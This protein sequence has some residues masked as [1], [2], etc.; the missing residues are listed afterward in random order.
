M[1][2]AL[3]G[4][5]T[6]GG[7]ATVGGAAGRNAAQRRA[8]PADEA[9]RQALAF[10]LR[11]TVEGEVRFDPG[12]RHLY[13]T[14]ASNYR[15]LPLGV[16]TPRHADDVAATLAAC[17]DAEVPVTLRGAGTSLAGQATN[18][19]VVLDVSRHLDTIAWVDPDA[20]L[21]RVEPGVVLAS[22]QAAAAPH[23]LMFGPD[24]ST[25]DRCTLGG[26]IGN[27]ACG[28]HSLTTGRT[29]HQVESLD[30]LLADG[31]RVD[32]G[33]VT[34][35]EAMRLAAAD[36]PMAAR[37]H[38]LLSLRGEVGDL[39]RD[40]FPRVP[41]RVSGYH[42]DQL[43]HADRLDVAKALVGTE[44]TC[45]VVLGATVRLVER[46]AARVLV[47]LG[48]RDLIEAARHVPA[49]L[50]HQP[51]ALE[52]VD[53]MLV[54]GAARP[55]RTRPR[56]LDLLPDGDG[57]LV[58]EFTG[59][60]V[61]EA[62]DA[63]DRLVRARDE[64]GA[65]THR[66]VTD[67]ADQAAV[68]RVRAEGLGAISVAP[69]QAMK[70]SG[71]E[72]AGVAPTRLADYLADLADLV[73]EHGLEAG[74]YGHF[75][76][77]CV[78]TKI[79]FDHTTDAGVATFRRFV[80]AAA[81][82]VVAHGG[83]P[84][85]EHGDGQARAEL[86]RKVFG[87]EL[88]D[89][90]RRFKHAWDP[91]GLL[92]PG[93][94]V[95][96]LPLDEGLRL[97]PLVEMATPARWFALAE[98]DGDLAGEAARCVGM[99]V[100]V[101]DQDTGTMCPSYMV[102][103]DEQHSTRGRAHLLFEV[104][105]PDTDLDGID[106]AHLHEALD[107]CL[108]CKACKA[109][110]PTGVD[111]ATL[112]AEV[113][114]QRYADRR[115]PAE[116]HALGRVRWWLRA[117]SRLPRLANAL[118]GS[119]V[120]RRLRPLVGVTSERPVPRLADVRFSTWWRRRG[121]SRVEGPPV[122][123]FV[124]TF[125]ET[126]E[127]RIGAAAV[128]VLEAAGRRVV[129]ASRPVCCGR[130]LYDHGMLD[131]AVT[132][133]RRLVDVLG[134]VAAGG[135]P[136][137]GLEPSCVA[138]L[139]DELPSLLTDDPAASAV[140]GATRTLS[141]FLLEVDWQPEGALDD[142]VEV[143]LHPHCQGRAVVGTDAD[144]ALLDRLGA[145]WRDLDAGCCGLAGAFGYRDDEPY[146]VSVAAAERKL[147]PSLRAAAPDALVLADG[148]SCRIQVAQL[149]GGEVPRPFHLAEVLAM[150]VHRGSGASDRPVPPRA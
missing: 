66:I 2:A 8:E 106:D 9:T 110:C 59:A 97:R 150:L 75:G 84:S 115:R 129:V 92:N 47:V 100:C 112:K 118:G 45:A 114:A 60:T 90:F 62:M 134:P 87:P 65:P 51:A 52:G 69:G 113:L 138:A 108:S 18:T 19:G 119:T 32:V 7:G 33:A 31:V 20:R 96:P 149:A 125:T 130:P 91:A 14:D 4:D 136:I 94:L 126:L 89:A 122:L 70:L 28:P 117:G 23:G 11:G 64:V 93:R 127:P 146:E 128:E 53:A 41:R 137:V 142:D 38:H 68:W 143:L 35:D 13:A 124:D 21:A 131:E 30:V 24:P 148:F 22:L 82:L 54:A 102:T 26:M 48:Y 74:M 44:G 55:G 83:S 57:W 80:E 95:D 43:L 67:P 6:V 50:P 16:V 76:D 71:W 63:A 56:G 81:D 17:R 111:V 121:G 49:L 98:D 10:A 3:G 141:E 145:R 72:D 105:R 15:H 107:L 78:H 1:G 79:D 101:R 25:A 29:V 140:A 135:V 103:R 46:P 12:S 144:A 123:L 73:R 40:R 99:G 36:G 5:A 104:L 86:Y 147:L 120:A 37:W 133:L 109:E 39:V 85:G 77:G 139:R 27:D 132:S 116:H 58:A 42:L 34:P 88:V 61:A